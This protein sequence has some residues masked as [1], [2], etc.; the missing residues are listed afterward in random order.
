MHFRTAAAFSLILSSSLVAQAIP[1]LSTATPITG[2]WSYSAAVGGSEARFS[3]ATGSPQLIVHCTR[4]T[5]HVTLSKPAPAAAPLI[6]VWTSSQ[7]RSLAASYNAATAR[8]S[9]ELPPYDALLDAISSSRG[10]FGV[11]AGSQA[12]LVV[13]PWPEIARVVEDCRA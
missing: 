5:R 7:T 10:R 1:D 8:L 6:D 4:A 3:D 9:V 13:P 12:A 2:A 11:S